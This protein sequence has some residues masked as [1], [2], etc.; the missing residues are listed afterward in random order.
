MERFECK[1]ISSIQTSIGIIVNSESRIL[2]Q[3]DVELRIECEMC[4]FIE[5]NA[6]I[7]SHSETERSRTDVW[8]LISTISMKKIKY[9]FIHECVWLRGEH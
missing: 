7:Y 5:S 2:Y 6:Q 8:F 9:L 1:P 4:A 3:I